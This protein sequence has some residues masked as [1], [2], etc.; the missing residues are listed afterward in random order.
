MVVL[1][2]GLFPAIDND[3]DTLTVFIRV[4]EN[5]AA[6]KHECKVGFYIFAKLMEITPE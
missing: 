4:R 2:K 1:Y 3:P 6:L 5:G